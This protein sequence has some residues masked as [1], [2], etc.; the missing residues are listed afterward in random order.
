MV[1]VRIKVPRIEGVSENDLVRSIKK[2]IQSKYEISGWQVSIEVIKSAPSPR[3]KGRKKV[4][5]WRAI[6]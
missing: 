2:F 1:E 3:L 5:E 6:D 4:G